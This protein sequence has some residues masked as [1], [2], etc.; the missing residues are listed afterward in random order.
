[1]N[2]ET[3]LFEKY[4]SMGVVRGLELLL[5]HADALRFIEDCEQL[6]LTILGM[7]FYKQEGSDIIELSGSADYSSLSGKEDAIER[8]VAAARRL[9]KDRL[10]EDATWVSFVVEE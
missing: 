7:D 8:S 5:R 1:M 9:I 4:R 3:R 2:A 10:P 6:G